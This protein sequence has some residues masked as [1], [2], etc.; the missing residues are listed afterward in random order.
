MDKGFGIRM[1]KHCPISPMASFA[2]RVFESYFQINISL[3]KSESRPKRARPV[4]L[5]TKTHVPSA[6]WNHLN[7]YNQRHLDII[8]SLPLILV[9]EGASKYNCVVPVSPSVDLQFL[10]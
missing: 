9:A 2:P 3:S 4:C 7:F 10:S 8:C 1:M 5:T 6:V